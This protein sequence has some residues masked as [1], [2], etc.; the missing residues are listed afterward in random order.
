MIRTL[1]PLFAGR[2][3]RTQW[4]ERNLQQ[5]ADREWLSNVVFDN[6]D[7]TK[8]LRLDDVDI[9]LI[10]KEADRNRKC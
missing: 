4:T 3:S 2:V 5:Y 9:A 1:F 7:K 10:L 8:D 6:W